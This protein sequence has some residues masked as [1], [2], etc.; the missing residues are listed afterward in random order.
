[1]FKNSFSVA[2]VRIFFENE[3][4]PGLADGKEATRTVRGF[5]HPN[6]TVY[7]QIGIN[8]SKLDFRQRLSHR[9]AGKNQ[10]AYNLRQKEMDGFQRARIKTKLKQKNSRQNC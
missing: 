9:N 1:M 4:F 2:A 6:Q 3:D 5:T 10:R 7:L 8:L